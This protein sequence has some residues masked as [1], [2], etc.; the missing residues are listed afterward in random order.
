MKLA[1]ISKKAK[2]MSK[3]GFEHWGT[4]KVKD[5]FPHIK[6]PKVYRNGQ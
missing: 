6:K 4:F 3:I 1:L 5:V 2:Q